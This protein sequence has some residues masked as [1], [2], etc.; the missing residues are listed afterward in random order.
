MASTMDF[1]TDGIVL[2]GGLANSKKLTDR[3]TS[4]VDGPFGYDA[5]ISKEAAENKNLADSQVAGDPDL[6]LFHNLETANAVGK[7]IKFHGGAKSGGLLL[8]ASVPVTFNSRSDR[9]ERRINSL[10]LACATGSSA[11]HL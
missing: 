1:N 10:L 7:A 6:I 8:G 2:T 3:L 5:C 11:A 4:K 9:A